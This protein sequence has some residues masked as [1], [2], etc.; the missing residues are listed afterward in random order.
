MHRLLLLCPVLGLPREFEGHCV[1]VKRS[2]V[3]VHQ[4]GSGD[5]PISPDLNMYTWKGR[6]SR[7]VSIMKVSPTTTVVWDQVRVVWFVHSGNVNKPE[8]KSL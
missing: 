5:N 1:R 7:L 8:L 3:E 6:G 2:V 4:Q